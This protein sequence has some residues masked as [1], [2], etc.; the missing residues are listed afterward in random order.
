MS[1]YG[2]DD[3]C[4]RDK[5]RNDTRFWQQVRESRAF[6][7]LIGAEGWRVSAAVTGVQL[8]A[9]HDGRYYN[10]VYNVSVHRQNPTDNI[11]RT[12]GTRYKAARATGLG[13]GL[14]SVLNI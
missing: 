12:Y 13:A 3:T 4:V 5:A 11:Q 6:Y 7:T 14:V 1:K 2:Y 8:S 9:L 10:I